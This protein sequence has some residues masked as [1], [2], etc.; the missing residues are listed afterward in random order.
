MK[1]GG[2]G[3]AVGKEL[4]KAAPVLLWLGVG[5]VAWKF[6]NQ[7]LDKL[8]EIFKGLTPKSSI[9]PSDEPV[10]RSKTGVM[11]ASI[12][13]PANN[14]FVA[15]SLIPFRQIRVKVAVNNPGDERQVDL[16]IQVTYYPRVGL[17]NL[18]SEVQTVKTSLQVRVPTGRKSY[19]VLVGR[20]GISTVDAV[21]EVFL[22]DQSAAIPA[23]FT[24]D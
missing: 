8:G 6:G 9:T 14:G 10:G 12:L 3:K 22:D 23:A 19:E 2:V 15:S 5:F 11:S 1:A 21:A 17:F 13:E 4:P 18:F 16:R 20:P 24:V 7:I